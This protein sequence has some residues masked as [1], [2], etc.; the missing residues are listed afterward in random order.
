M[1]DISL[2][3]ALTQNIWDIFARRFD[4]PEFCEFMQLPEECDNCS[5]KELCG[6]GC[7]AG[8]KILFGSYTKK[9]CR[10]LGPWQETV[11]SQELPNKI[12]SF[13]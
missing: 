9:D 7:K 3:N 11:S 5:Y 4:S 8:N 13:F 6:G 2:G 1:H 10:C 12:P